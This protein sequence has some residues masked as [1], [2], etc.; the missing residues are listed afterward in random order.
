MKTRV[1]LLCAA[2]T[3]LLLTGVVAANGSATI[4]WHAVGAGGDHVEADAHTL[5]YTMGQAVIGSV[6]NDPYDVCAGYWCGAAADYSVLLPVV[7]RAHP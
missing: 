3:C 6:G 5:D 1:A 2:A 7:M 4:D